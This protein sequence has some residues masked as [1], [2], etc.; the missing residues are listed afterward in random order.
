VDTAGVK[1][2]T[3]ETTEVKRNTTQCG[4]KP[5][6]TKEQ[7]WILPEGNKPLQRQLK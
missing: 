4:T 3:S 6:T 5:A 1:Q 7:R 2:T